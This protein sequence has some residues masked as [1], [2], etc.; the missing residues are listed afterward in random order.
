MSAIVEE[1]RFVILREGLSK[2]GPSID[3]KQFHDSAMHSEAPLTPEEQR[4]LR[5][6]LDQQAKIAFAHAVCG[7]YAFVPTSSE[8]F[9]SDKHEEIAREDRPR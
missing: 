7:K 1:L 6:S 2:A 4:Q 3:L 9:A 8:T 5:E